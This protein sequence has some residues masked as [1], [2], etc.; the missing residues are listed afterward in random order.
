METEK[1]KGEKG[2]S[3]DSPRRRELLSSPAPPGLELQEIRV[4]AIEAYDASE[5]AS[6]ARGGVERERR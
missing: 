3:N 6:A 2:R 4:N 1:R 5:R